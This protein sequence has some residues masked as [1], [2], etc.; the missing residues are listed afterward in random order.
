MH[1]DIIVTLAVAVFGSTG[2]W[3]WITT[4]NRKRS[5][6]DRLL[7][8]LAYDKILWQCNKYI[9]QGHISAREYNELEKYMFEPYQEL[10]GNGTAAKLMDE[11][12]RLPTKE[13]SDE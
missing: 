10:G 1:I 7:L 12:R 5:A 3:T 11:V 13:D 2:F 4:R 6:E 8:G 9:T